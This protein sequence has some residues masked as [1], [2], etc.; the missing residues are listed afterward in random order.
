MWEKA[1]E[2]KRKKSAFEKI[3]SSTSNSEE[4]EVE[5]FDRVIPL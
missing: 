2:C 5:K 1:K 4:E 3:A